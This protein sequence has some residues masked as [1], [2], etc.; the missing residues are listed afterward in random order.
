MNI[1]KPNKFIEFIKNT[2]HIYSAKTYKD[3]SIVYCDY[4]KNVYYVTGEFKS[5]C[6]Y[7]DAKKHGIEIGYY[8]SGQMLYETSYNNDVKDGIEK[9]HYEN[10]KLMREIPFV[11]GKAHCI[12]KG[13]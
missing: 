5:E 13:Y 3:G 11:N 4:I 8:K 12:Y 10:G 1:K 6:P 9:I 2:L 7:T